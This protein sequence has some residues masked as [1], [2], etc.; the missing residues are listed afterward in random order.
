MSDTPDDKK[1]R[2]DSILIARLPFLFVLAAVSTAAAS[3]Y[4]WPW[5][6]GN[7]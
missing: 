7:H 5:V 6:M 4:L 3:W 1:P 2:R